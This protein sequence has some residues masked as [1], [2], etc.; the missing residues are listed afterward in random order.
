[1]KTVASQLPLYLFLSKIY[2]C[3]SLNE[4]IQTDFFTNYRQ[5]LFYE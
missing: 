4:V 1:M 3:E 5:G 2:Q